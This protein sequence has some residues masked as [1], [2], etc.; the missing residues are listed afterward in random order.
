MKTRIYMDNSNLPQLPKYKYSFN[1][2]IHDLNLS[3]PLESKSLFSKIGRNGI[4]PQNSLTIPHK[5]KS[6]GNFSLE[7][8]NSSI[9][10]YNEPMSATKNSNKLR[11]ITK[12]YGGFK[13]P[14]LKKKESNPEEVSKVIV[15]PDPYYQAR[16]LKAL[17]NLKESSYMLNLARQHFMQTIEALKIGKHMK[18]KVPQKEIK[19]SKK[20]P[21]FKTIFLDMDETL[22]H[23]D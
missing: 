11:K 1:S 13:L 21:K 17:T 22:M 8:I 2:K 3:T 20:N 5:I 23:C 16:I 12:D 15:T 19:L 6:G 7:K 4:S 18:P 14:G 10:D 9:L